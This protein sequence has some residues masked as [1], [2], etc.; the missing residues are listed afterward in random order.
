VYDRIKKLVDDALCGYYLKKCRDDVKANE[1]ACSKV[2]PLTLA[3]QC[4]AAGRT[5]CNNGGWLYVQCSQLRQ[6]ENCRKTLECGADL[7]MPF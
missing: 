2:D 6:D 4:Q 1:A 3:E 5:D 7:T